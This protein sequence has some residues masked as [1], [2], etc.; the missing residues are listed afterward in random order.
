[1]SEADFDHRL[2]YFLKTSAR[3]I[4]EKYYYVGIKRYFQKITRPLKMVVLT[5]IRD[6]GGDDRNG[7]FIKT[8]RGEKYMEGIIEAFHKVN[9]LKNIEMVG[10][11][12]DD[13]D[14]NESDVKK[15]KDYSAKPTGGKSWIFDINLKDRN[16]NKVTSL[17]QNIP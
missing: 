10:I 6:I 12:T 14:S 13:D 8:P 15:M 5:S 17:V 9:F 11:I 1:M 16:G 7:S 2:K 3:N 4:I